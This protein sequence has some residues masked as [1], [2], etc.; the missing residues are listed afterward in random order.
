MKELTQ[1]M[2]VLSATLSTVI[3]SPKIV[4]SENSVEPEMTS[5]LGSGAQRR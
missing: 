1:C 5:Y 3:T 2:V 4:C